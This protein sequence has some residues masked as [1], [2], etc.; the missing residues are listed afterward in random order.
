[1]TTRFSTFP[2]FSNYTYLCDRL[3]PTQNDSVHPN[4]NP[5]S[6][7]YGPG[8]ISF[9]IDVPLNST[10]EA[11]TLV[12]QVRLTDSSSPALTIAC[13]NVHSSPYIAHRWYWKMIMWLPIA[14][15]IGFLVLALCASMIAAEA[16]QR[17]AFK[18]RAREGG[19]PKLIRDKLSPMIVSALSGRGLVMSPALLRFV[20][21]GCWDIIFHLQ[22]L[23]AIAMCHVQWPDFAYPFLRQAAWSSLLGNVTLTQP[24]RDRIDPLSTNA[25]LPSGDLGS[26]MSNPSSPLYLNASQSNILL[27]LQENNDGVEI[28]ASMIGLRSENLFG[29]CLGI[30]LAIVAAIIIFSLLIWFIDCAIQSHDRAEKRKEE[31]QLPLPSSPGMDF[32]ELDEGKAWDK[33]NLRRNPNAKSIFRSKSTMRGSLTTA[34]GLHGRTLHGNLVR[35]LILFHL[36][37]TIVSVYQFS[38]AEEHSTVSVALAAL[39]FALFSILFP[40]YIMI[41]IARTPL[42]K[43]YEHV[44]TLLALGPVYHFYSPG[45]QLFYMVS[46]AHSLILGIVVGAARKSGAAQ[47]IVIL[48]VEVLA[49]LASS[50]WLPWGEG[51]MMG[52]LS[53]MASVVRIITAILVLLLTSLVSLGFSARNWLTYVLL[54]LQAIYLGG[55]LLVFIVKLVEA[56]VRAVWKV[57]FDER[58]SARTAGLGGAI[59]K[60]RRRKLKGQRRESTSSSV[61][62]QRLKMEHRMSNMSDGSTNT[63]SHMLRN[64]QQI[65]M[66]DSRLG[67][68]ADYLGAGMPRPL[69]THMN[70]FNRMDEESG[71]IMAALPPVSPTGSRVHYPNNPNPAFVRMGGGKATDVNPYAALPTSESVQQRPPLPRSRPQSQSGIVGDWN[72]QK[73][74]KDSNKSYFALP[75]IPVQ[76]LSSTQ[77]A[78]LAASRSIQAQQMRK[79]QRQ[80]EALG[81]KKEGNNKN[82]LFGKQRSKQSEEVEEDSSDEGTTWDSSAIARNKGAWSGVAKMSAALTNMK[83]NIMGGKQD[84]ATQSEDETEGGVPS[85]PPSGSGGF[86]VVRPVRPRAIPSKPDITV[87]KGE[88]SI[89]ASDR[90]SQIISQ[91]QNFYST[92]QLGMLGAD[93]KRATSSAGHT[94]ELASEDRFWLP[95]LDLG[96]SKEQL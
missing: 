36:P 56:F 80:Q 34:L 29:T 44:G 1:M 73:T 76:E 57:R 35:A 48:I 15:V 42:Q 30:W 49:A 87:K 31:A 68:Y 23:V 20:T 24:L 92:G 37:I 53:F 17:S 26:A 89:I 21:P 4:V 71:H 38:L 64:S 3:Y 6:C 81:K 5:P 18:N 95:P 33:D 7:Q 25:F 86:E 94:E 27:N 69:S 58:I 93:L 43:L 46:F 67:S 85:L 82:F 47:A 8:T 51:A 62:L 59:R 52:P 22:F 45:S 78:A 28:F 79:E 91:Q 60:I 40:L 66:S 13:I 75:K 90:E 50:L 55:A 65:P 10:Y 14:L 11:G 83:K 96:G 88:E 74:V 84:A 9:G 19:A 16:A 63:M 54:L 70:S 12:T 39:A 2:V 41:R 32:T 61:R 72:Q 77:V